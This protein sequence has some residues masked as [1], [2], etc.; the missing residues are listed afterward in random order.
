GLV[1]YTMAVPDHDRPMNVLLWEL[2]GHGPKVDLRPSLVPERV[3]PTR[4]AFERAA[5]A[6]VTV[7]LVGPR[8]HAGSGMTR[9]ALRGGRYRPA[10]GI[11]DL[12]ATAAE[13]LDAPDGNRALVYGY[14]ADLDLIGHVRG[15]RSDAWRVQL[16]QV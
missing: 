15:T 10:F 11:G 14:H 9:A 1:G 4:T 16:R 8:Q 5:A 2:Y 6:G 3:Q 13:A 7:T 12:V